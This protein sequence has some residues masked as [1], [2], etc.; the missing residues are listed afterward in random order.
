MQKYIVENTEMMMELKSI[1]S[2]V[3]FQLHW[4][5]VT[6]YVFTSFHIFAFYE[7]VPLSRYIG[8]K[9]DCNFPIDFHIVTRQMWT[10]QK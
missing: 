5:T 3:E 10:H 7:Y 9:I 1:K 8:I 4:Y 2:E 6:I